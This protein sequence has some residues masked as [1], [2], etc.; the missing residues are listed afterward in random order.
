MQ[1]EKVDAGWTK[2]PA[3]AE[4]SESTTSTEERRRPKIQK[5]D[6]KINPIF[7]KDEEEPN[8]SLGSGNMRFVFLLYN[9]H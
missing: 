6:R 3:P 5:N 1:P 9:I 4:A 8:L 2:K 7:V